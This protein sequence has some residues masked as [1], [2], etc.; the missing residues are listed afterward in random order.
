[1]TMEYHS[2]YIIKKARRESVL[3]RQRRRV[4]LAVLLAALVVWLASTG[5]FT[6]ASADYTNGIYISVNR[7]DSLWSIAGKHKPANTDTRAFM[8]TI[9][10]LNSMDSAAVYEG[11]IL[12]IPV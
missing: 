3:N 12:Y 6:P 4:V 1:M 7:G 11:Q 2:A 8:R 10:K 9:T 5:V